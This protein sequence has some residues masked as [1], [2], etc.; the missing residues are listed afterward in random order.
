MRAQAAVEKDDKRRRGE[1]VGFG[2]G[3]GGE[4]SRGID[5][6]TRTRKVVECECR[7]GGGD[8]NG[9]RRRV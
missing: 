4:E 1:D 5:E 8:G 7:G 2:E 3:D 9:G 6:V